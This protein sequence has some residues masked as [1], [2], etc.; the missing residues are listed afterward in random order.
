MKGVVGDNQEII[1]VLMMQ[2]YTEGFSEIS[3]NPSDKVFLPNSIDGI[4][5]FIQDKEK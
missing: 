1:K 4:R 2:K 5:L 3:K